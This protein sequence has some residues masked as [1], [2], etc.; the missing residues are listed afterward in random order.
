MHADIALM[1]ACCYDGGATAV[2]GTDKLSHMQIYQC[3]VTG[4]HSN[5]MRFLHKQKVLSGLSS[6]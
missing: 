5:A 2:H 1:A 3:P 6:N 4:I